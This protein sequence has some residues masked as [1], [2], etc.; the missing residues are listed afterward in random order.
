MEQPTTAGGVAP[1]PPAWAGASRAG[2]YALAAFGI[3][4]ALGTL[5]LN[6]PELSPADLGAA[7]SVL[8]ALVPLA[9][10]GGALE[11]AMRPRDRAPSVETVDGRGVRF[12]H[13]SRAWQAEVAFYVSLLPMPVSFLA[14]G[15]AGFLAEGLTTRTVFA[16]CLGLSG[17]AAVGYVLV[18]IAAGRI[19]RGEVTITDEGVT[20]RTSTDESRLSWDDVAG[21]EAVDEKGP[22]LK[23]LALPGRTASRTEHARFVGPDTKRDL[24]DL[25]V[26]ATLVEGDAALL[27]HAVAWYFSHPDARAE[28]RSDAALRRVR[29]G[30]AVTDQASLDG[31]ASDGASA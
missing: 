26:D 21:V 22:R 30:E 19:R 9:V 14:I 15:T 17:A 29:A 5:V 20:H 16:L 27:A 7:P 28:L 12:R 13:R 2:S 24:P 23:L 25:V 1:M 10:A 11:R 6:V 8:F 31:A 3:V 4:V 18:C